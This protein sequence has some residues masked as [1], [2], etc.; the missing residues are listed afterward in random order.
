MRS[1][2]PFVTASVPIALAVG[3]GAALL[4]SPAQAATLVGKPCTKAGA[5]QGDGPGRTVTCVKVTT[6]KNKGKLVWELIQGP[7]PGPGAGCTSRPVFTKDFISPDQVQV[8][9]PIGE[10][11][12]FG[13]VLSVRSYVHS[14]PELDGQPLPLYAPVNMTLTQAAYY[15]VSTDPAYKPEY[16]LYFDVGCGV[17]L[18]FYHVK[19]VVGAVAKVVP[20]APAPSSAGQPMTPTRVKAGEQ[21]GWFQG[22]AGKSV[23]FDLRVEDASRTNTFINQARFASSPDASGELHAV[24][25]YDFYAGAQRE[26]SLSKLGA[27]SGNPVSGTACGTINQG[28]AGTAQ[29]MWFF[30]DAKVNDL[31]Y[32]GD[33]WSDGIPAGQ[34]QSQVIFSVDPGGTVRIGGLNARAPMGQMMVSQQG[35][36]SDTWKHPQSIGAGAEHCW[37]N[38]SQSVK[39]RLSADGASLTAVVGTGACTTLDLARGQTYVR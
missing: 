2:R 16:S 29:G 13:G 12:A 1:Y 36:G 35:T 8:V 38:S 28:T 30:A 6:G 37:S 11:T 7:N 26:R 3:L 10:Q 20:K 19:G 24:C 14:K 18:Q 15:K 9:V 39:V 32:R 34:Y 21:I 17:Q 33:T 5:T 22:E 23:A 27:P 31:T 4:A 25:P